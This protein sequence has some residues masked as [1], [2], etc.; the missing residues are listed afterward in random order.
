[1]LNAWNSMEKIECQKKIGICYEYWTVYDVL[2][3][4][5]IVVIVLSVDVDSPTSSISINFLPI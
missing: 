1:M 5:C 3:R 4:G 2:K